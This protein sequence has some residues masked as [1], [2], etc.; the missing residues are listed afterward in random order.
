MIPTRLSQWIVA[1]L[2]CVATTAVSGAA[3]ARIGHTAPII[4]QTMKVTVDRV[5]PGERIALV[6]DSGII[7][8][9]TAL[10]E[11]AD[12]SGTARFD[13]PLEW[14][15]T[16]PSKA[17]AR[18]VL[19]WESGML[20]RADGSDLAGM[21][22]FIQAVNPSR[23]ETPL[24]TAEIGFVSPSLLVTGRANGRAGL[25]HL[26]LP[27]FPGQSGM[28][29]LGTGSPGGAVYDG[30]GNRVFVIADGPSGDLRV[31]VE[32]SSTAQPFLAN[33]AAFARDLRGIAI[34]AD[35]RTILV[36][37]AGEGDPTLYVIDTATDE[38]TAI[39][40]DDLGEHGGRVVVSE[41]G[42]FGFVSVR[43]LYV[44]QIDLLSRSPGHLLAI[45]SP[46]QDEIRDLRVIRGNLFAL[47]GRALS[48]SKT[49]SLTGLE[50]ANL[51]HYS[52]ESGMTARDLGVRE[53]RGE[54]EILLMDP[55]E[56]TI[57]VFDARTMQ[58]RATYDGLP[59]GA[60][61][62]L[63]PADP[64]SPLAA[65]LEGEPGG[66]SSLRPVHLGLLS[67]RSPNAIGE[68][69]ALGGRARAL[70]L[71]GSAAMGAIY[72]LHIQ[73]TGLV[74][75]PASLVHQSANTGRAIDLTEWTLVALPADF[76]VSSA[77]AL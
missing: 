34:T 35:G 37:A 1:M 29:D 50:V 36:S 24:A 14:L 63:L 21:T 47:T 51:G 16:D 12:G 61:G 20:F 30:R 15:P 10:E 39:P 62:L 44:R 2:A 59:L 76:E 60:N 38:V 53:D 18:Q 45:G 11:I 17:T 40:I 3:P 77:S 32:G 68:S 56:G 41:G 73:R 28:I 27:K 42:L 22:R 57:A 26:P 70:P 13:L 5:W 48:S 71:E 6:F 46:G 69:V 31:V 33:G 49:D 66:S 19:A 25:Y 52:Q 75:V 43:S 54:T 8:R 23:P 4:G 67:A 74:A 58:R 55:A 72:V 65:L 9:V 64:T 7:G